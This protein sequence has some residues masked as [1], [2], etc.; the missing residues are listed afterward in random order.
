VILVTDVG[1]LLHQPYWLDE[2]WVADSVRAPLSVVP[3]LASSTPLGWTLLLRL[4]PFGGPERQ[5]LVPLAFYALAV[6]I[7]YLLGRELRLTR[8]A[9]GLLTAA[10]VLLAPSMLARGDLK[11]YTAEACSAVLLWLLVA[12]VETTWGRW[13]LTAL[14]VTAS[15]GCLFASTAIFTGSAAFAC[16]G[17]ECLVRR[18]WRRL[19]ELAVAGVGALVIFAVVY[20]VVLRPQI[21][22]GLAN[23]WRPWYLPGNKPNALLF[24]QAQLARVAPYLAVAGRS[25]I[26]VGLFVG[27]MAALGVVAL[28]RMGRYALAALLPAT[29]AVSIVASAA[30][31]YPFGDERTSTF[32]L[33]MVPVL[34]AIGVAA[35]IHA[36][37]SGRMT[38]GTTRS[39]GGARARWAAALAATAVAVTALATVNA[40]W[41]SVREIAIN[42]ENPY[43]Q[44]TYVEAHFRPG[45]VILVNEEAT[46]AFAYYYKT[47]PGSYPATTVTANGFFPAYPDDPR[48][49]ALT[50]RDQP[51]IANAVARAVDMIAAE[52]PGHRGR[53][54]AIRD[55]LSLEETAYW[56]YALA[57]GTATTIRFP[58]FQGHS[59]EAL[60]LYRPAIRAA[61]PVALWGASVAQWQQMLSIAAPGSTS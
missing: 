49:I 48:I 34:M 17:L 35:V 46:Y 26:G 24:L 7:A 37:S 31:L 41:I 47:P 21:N 33:V 39:P 60:L 53:I 6:A 18:Q 52:R 56:R 55:H 45:D 28:A 29:L 54:W 32:W 57:G 16:L 36:V 58:R 20:V 42:P 1:Y 22:L 10:A 25:G 61:A 59:P 8:F 44:I 23:Y 30:R 51:T 50:N 38:P 12:R 4:V 14:A 3:R 5:R 11:Q 15:A 27:A 2:A 13:R 19:A 43:D 9:S 40:R